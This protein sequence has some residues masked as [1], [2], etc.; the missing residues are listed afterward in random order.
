MWYGIGVVPGAYAA[1]TFRCIQPDLFT[2][3]HY[4]IWCA[5]GYA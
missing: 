4:F 1:N 3:L 5:S 2:W